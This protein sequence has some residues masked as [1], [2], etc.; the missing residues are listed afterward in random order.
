MNG[1]AKLL[2]TITAFLF[3]TVLVTGCRERL[4]RYRRQGA[5]KESSNSLA[6]SATLLSLPKLGLGTELLPWL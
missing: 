5:D 3:G 4:L 1:T 2:L 6:K